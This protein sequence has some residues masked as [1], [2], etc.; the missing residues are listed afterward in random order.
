MLLEHVKMRNIIFI[1]LS[2]FSQL[3][4]I[5]GLDIK[6]NPSVRIIP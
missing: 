4:L 6:R 5:L 2:L 1:S 3:L